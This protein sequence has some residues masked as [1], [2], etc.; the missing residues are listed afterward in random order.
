MLHGG[1]GINPDDLTKSLEL[2]VVK[3]NIGAAV[4]EAWISGLEE[5]V[6]KKSSDSHEPRHYGISKHAMDKV[7][8]AARGRIRLL[9]ASN[10][11]DS[12][13]KA[14]QAED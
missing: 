11:A 5:G 10:R 6:A 9:R 14:L 13:K 2:G 12:M 7:T 1:S 8:E 4:F 3:V